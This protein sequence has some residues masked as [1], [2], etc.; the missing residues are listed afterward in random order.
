MTPAQEPFQVSD[1]FHDGCVPHV[2]GVFQKIHILCQLGFVQRFKSQPL[3]KLFKVLP[4]CGKFLI[5]GIRPA[6]LRTAGFVR[7]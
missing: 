5:G 4:Y 7:L 2:F 1:L 3:V 6:V